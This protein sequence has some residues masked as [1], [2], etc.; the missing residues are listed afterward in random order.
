VRIEALRIPLA[1]GLLVLVG[2]A[3]ACS[4]DTD[5]YPGSKC[6]K[7][8]PFELYGV[9]AGGIQP[10]NQN[11]RQP[12]YDPMDTNRTVGNTCSFDV[13]CG[14][15]NFCYKQQTFALNGVCLRRR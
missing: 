13:D 14:P 2:Q 8:N 11:D 9:C 12:V 4:F 10:G 5:C 3:L 7:G 15:G 1:S 6:I